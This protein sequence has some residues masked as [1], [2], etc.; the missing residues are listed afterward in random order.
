MQLRRQRFAKLVQHTNAAIFPQHEDVQTSGFN[1]PASFGQHLPEEL[2]D[3]VM[4]VRVAGRPKHE[5]LRGYKFLMRSGDA[6]DDLIEA[7]NSEPARIV[8]SN[9]ESVTLAMWY[10]ALNGRR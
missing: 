2:D 6:S 7:A 5:T 4:H 3:I 1:W 10:A 9:V 8:S